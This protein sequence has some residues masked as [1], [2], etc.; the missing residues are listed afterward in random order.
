METEREREKEGWCWLR[1]EGGGA[2][3][4]GRMPA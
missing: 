2:I 4:E 1:R 3:R